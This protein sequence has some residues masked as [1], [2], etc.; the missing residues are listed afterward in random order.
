MTGVLAADGLLDVQPDPAGCNRRRMASIRQEF[1]DRPAAVVVAA[2]GVPYAGYA[3]HTAR[4]PAT[5]DRLEPG[6]GQMSPNIDTPPLHPRTVCTRG[7][8]PR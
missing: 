8:P 4:L 2:S 5:F 3:E 1:E 6:G 7:S